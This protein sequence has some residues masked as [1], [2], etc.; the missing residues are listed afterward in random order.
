MAMFGKRA[1]GRRRGGGAPG[2]LSGAVS[3]GFVVLAAALAA[4]ALGARHYAAGLPQAAALA[5]YDP[6]T[7]T[8]LHAG[9]G[10]LLAEYAT[11]RRVFVPLEAMP[12]MLV[13][14]F[15]AAEDQRFYE[16]IGIDPIG[17]ARAMLQNLRN[18]GSGRRPVGGS[19]ITQ[20]VAKNFFLS[21][22]LSLARK[23]REALLALRIERAISKDR[24]LELYVNEIFL[25]RRAYGVAA[26][27]LN[28]FDKSLDD[29]TLSEMA[30]LAGLPKAPSDYN[31]LRR[32]EAARARR[33]YVVGRLLAD[34][35]IDGAAAAAA[36]AEPIEV[37]RRDP[38]GSVRA[39]YFAEEARRLLLAR[40]GED[41]LY[42]GGLAVRTTVDPGLQAIADRA[43][44]DGLVA[45][46]RRH[47]WRGPVATLAT[48]G[49]W[50]SAL[51]AVPAPPGLAP[52]RLALV[53]G[54]TRNA[55]DIGFADGSAGAI[56]FDEVKWARPWRREQRVGPAPDRIGA[57][58]APGDVVAVEA[59]AGGGE[60]DG[61]GAPAARFALRQMPD[62]QGAAIALD[63][64]TGRV[65]AMTGGWS[66]D[67]SQ[68]NRATQALRQPGSA[69]KPFV[70]LA[71]LE[72]GY[73][74]ADTIVDGPLAIEQGPG[75][76]LWRPENYSQE[77]YGPTA[78]RRGLEKSRNLMTVR[79]ANKIGPQAVSEI[80]RRFGIGDF[81]ELLS[82]ALGAGETTLLRLAAAYGMVVN[83]GRWI[84]PAF[85]ERIQDRYGRTVYRRDARACGACA[86]AESAPARPPAL[87]DA[88]ARVTDPA[89]AF[90]LAWM[91]RGAV[92]RGTGV[93]AA[94][95]G[96]PLA[97]KT[98]TSNDS[99]DTWFIGF[100]PDLVVGVF[101]G[102]DRPRTLG[103][104]QTGSNVALPVFVSIME[105]ALGGRPATPFRMPANV[106]MARIDAET[107]GPPVPDSELVIVEAFKPGTEPAGAAP[108]PPAVAAAAAGAEDAPRPEP[109]AFDASGLY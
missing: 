73:T 28:Y 108:S 34:G 49:D 6:P 78:L 68:F 24:I 89:S 38:A 74:P 61:E 88:R 58:L 62:I 5:A 37:R 55:A 52:W 1:A 43:L 35:R 59:L 105:Q 50:P 84:E 100:S 7:I 27:A 79:L 48:D 72:N 85:V 106:L 90:Q 22:D 45:Y 103:P 66:F 57:V 86:G 99:F 26:A 75:L 96:R 93:R 2:F 15:V 19:S 97:G 21:S 12:R 82:M 83:G 81:P 51:A 94:R 63:P 11:E 31:P 39:P 30:F 32:P 47:G 10:R 16:H 91:L 54:V 98:G 44:R 20:Q 92:E 56:P 33:D 46:D 107:G 42:R 53:R 36:M 70:Y 64:H 18:L 69:F 40:Y 25:G 104:R 67:E 14:A 60:E 13:H 71:A 80:G 95:L 4:A 9:D 77:Y 76:P 3:A 65:L 17:V 8:R 109:A 41:A 29:L 101:V 102:F 23:F 87:R